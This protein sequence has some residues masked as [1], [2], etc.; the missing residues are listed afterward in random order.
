MSTQ[1]LWF[2]T[3]GAGIVSLL[4]FTVVVG[5]G[6]MTSVRWQARHWPHGVIAPTRTRWPIRS[7]RTA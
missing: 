1:V 6:V 5:L 2:A 3:R 4:L 7:T